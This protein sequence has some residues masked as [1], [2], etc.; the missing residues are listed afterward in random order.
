MSTSADSTGRGFSHVREAVE[1]ALEPVIN[2]SLDVI[3]HMQ[4]TGSTERVMQAL[5]LR[6]HLAA[7]L[8]PLVEAEKAAA[9]REAADEMT[10][11]IADGD[12]ADLAG[13]VPGEV[14]RAS[15]VQG[16]DSLYEEP[17]QWLRDCAA[18]YTTTEGNES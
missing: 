17:D 3:D 4:R 18:T 16:R 9:L 2:E 6:D 13:Y 7:V 8:A 14:G 10:R 15:A 12:V 11:V 1:R 5:L